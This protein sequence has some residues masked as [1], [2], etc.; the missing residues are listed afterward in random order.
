MHN[1]KFNF[2]K[3]PENFF[4]NYPKS[5]QTIHKWNNLPV[6]H[7]ACLHIRLAVCLLRLP[8]N[9]LLSIFDGCREPCGMKSVPF[10]IDNRNSCRHC[11]TC[12]CPLTMMSLMIPVISL[13]SVWIS[14]LILQIHEVAVSI[15]WIT[16]LAITACF[17]LVKWNW[18]EDE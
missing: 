15:R 3:I 1:A 18:I 17:V 8:R 16:A 11:D 6:G 13:T 7:H 9:E 4:Q 10:E 14:G 12:R 5:E 2:T